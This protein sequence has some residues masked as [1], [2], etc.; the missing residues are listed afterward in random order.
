MP[1][2]LTV[3]V[4]VERVA[5][6]P[7]EVWVGEPER[8]AVTAGLRVRVAVVVC[9]RVSD[10]PGV[11]VYV[12]LKLGVPLRVG[13]ADT[14]QANDVLVVWEAVGVREGLGPPVPVGVADVVGVRVTARLAVAAVALT[15][16]VN[17]LLG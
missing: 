12:E 16:L 9:D 14:V 10:W 2:S 17:V 1:D 8:D 4:A 7:V 3:Q 11:G 5:K 15:V 6:V 13:E